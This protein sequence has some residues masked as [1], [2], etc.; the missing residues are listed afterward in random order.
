MFDIIDDPVKVG[1]DEPKP[2]KIIINNIPVYCVN[3]PID[4]ETIPIIFK[5]HN[6]FGE[7]NS[8][9]ILRI[10]NHLNNLIKAQKIKQNVVDINKLVNNLHNSM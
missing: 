8:D 4:G 1:D 10:E 9:N 2:Y 7:P 3:D 6:Y 5:K